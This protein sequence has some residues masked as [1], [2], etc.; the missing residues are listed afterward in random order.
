[1]GAARRRGPTAQDS[2]EM[3]VTMAWGKEKSS[4]LRSL[5]VQCIGENPLRFPPG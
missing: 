1:M 3:A 5:D 2:V 4:R